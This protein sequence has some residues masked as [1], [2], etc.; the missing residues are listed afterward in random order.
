MSGRNSKRFNDQG[1]PGEWKAS[2]IADA[3]AETRVDAGQVALRDSA[4]RKASSPLRA[5]FTA[6]KH[7]LTV[8]NMYFTVT[9]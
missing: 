4:T 2:S 8:N 7:L 6:C 3:V 1:I 9:P 5:I